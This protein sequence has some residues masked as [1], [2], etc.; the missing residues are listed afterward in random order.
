MGFIQEAI[1]D[2]YKDQTFY[3]SAK[4]YSPELK[5]QVIDFFRRKGVEG[6]QSEYSFVGDKVV[7]SDLKDMTPEARRKSFHKAIQNFEIGKQFFSVSSS[8]D[9]TIKF[10]A[11]IIGDKSVL[12]ILKS[13]E[14]FFESGHD[15]EVRITG[16]DD[17]QKSTKH[18]INL[19]RPINQVLEDVWSFIQQSL[20]SFSVE[21]K[22]KE[23]KK[24]QRKYV[25]NDIE[26]IVELYLRR[27]HKTLKSGKKVEL[28]YDQRW[29]DFGVSMNYKDQNFKSNS[30]STATG[31]TLSV[32][33]KKSK[34]NKKAGYRHSVVKPE[35]LEMYPDLD[36][37]RTILRDA[38]TDQNMPEGL[39]RLG[40]FV[41][42]NTIRP[43][44]IEVRKRLDIATEKF[45][46]MGYVPIDSSRGYGRDN[47]PSIKFE[48]REKVKQEA[49]NNPSVVDRIMRSQRAGGNLDR[50]FFSNISRPEQFY[51]NL[52][53]AFF[54][55]N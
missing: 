22:P 43:E 49:A 40:E 24:P 7:Y 2:F 36:E 3:T 32:K 10:P 45:I 37:I 55:A 51:H 54:H 30:R 44:H 6:W 35:A 46:K 15:I 48:Y 28:D 13:N 5:K 25:R 39:K 11:M 26:R 50:A 53:R 14:E 41:P 33:L 20:N 8:Y 34:K 19:M 4:K 17:K 9:A 16:G 1:N 21:P 42:E 18:K 27:Q 47:P 38:Y 23:E 12:V 31:F 29:V 52:L